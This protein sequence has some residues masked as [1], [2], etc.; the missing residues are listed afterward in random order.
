MNASPKVAS[1]VVH[2]QPHT[3]VLASAD[4]FGSRASVQ[5]LVALLAANIKLGT[6]EYS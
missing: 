4:K 6:V 5:H 2:G 3:L 1:D